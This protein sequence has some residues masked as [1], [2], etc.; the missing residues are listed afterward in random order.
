MT[1]KVESN[2]GQSHLRNITFCTV[3]LT[4]AII[5]INKKNKYDQVVARRNYQYQ[6]GELSIGTDET[7]AMTGSKKKFSK[8][9]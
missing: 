3:S 4:N 1:K 7:A 5:V 9:A 8:N 2:T 6:L